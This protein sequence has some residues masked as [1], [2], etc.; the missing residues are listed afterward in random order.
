MIN[1]HLKNENL[2]HMKTMYMKSK[3]I[4]KKAKIQDH[5]FRNTIRQKETFSG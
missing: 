1:L 3:K 5:S 4:F 2:S